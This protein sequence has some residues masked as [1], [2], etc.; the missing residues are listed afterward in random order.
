MGLAEGA[1]EPAALTSSIV[2]VKGTDTELESLL[3]AWAA[4]A[5]RT[6]R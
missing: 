1:R 3:W 6:R 5:E 4:D 2:G